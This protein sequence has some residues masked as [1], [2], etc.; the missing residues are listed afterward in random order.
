MKKIVKKRTYLCAMLTVMLVFGNHTGEYVY[1]APG[2][3]QT[4]TATTKESSSKEDLSKENLS[5]EDLSKENVTKENPADSSETPKLT[6]EELAAY[7]SDSVFIGDSI[8]LGFRNYSAKQKSYVHNIQFLAVGSYSAFNAMKPVTSDSVHPMYK[9]KKYQ[10]WN[11]V[12]LIGS[13]RAFILLG[14]NDIS[15]LGLE[16]AR[17]QYKALIDK[18][19]ETSPDIEIHIVS[20]TYTLSDQGKG[21]LNNENI[22]QYNILLQ[23]MAEENGWGYIDLC[24]LLSD[25]KGNLDKQYCSDGYVHLSNTAYALWESELINYANMQSASTEVESETGVDSETE[26]VP[27]TETETKDSKSKME[28]ILEADTSQS[29]KGR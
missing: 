4:E 10:V 9:G 19:L 13:K 28:T 18:I 3:E 16:G 23:E 12:P 15:I 8:M 26:T 2:D 20:V 25:G 1:A 22:A 27:S 14:M 24:T 17:D 7:Y 11:A 29:T 5:K 6:D 21:K